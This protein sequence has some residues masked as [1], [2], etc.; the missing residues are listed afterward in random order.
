MLCPG[1]FILVVVKSPI[2]ACNENTAQ[3]I[4]FEKSIQFWL[5]ASFASITVVN[6]YVVNFRFFWVKIL[7]TGPGNLKSSG[8]FDSASRFS[9][10]TPENVHLTPSN[11]E[12]LIWPQ[13]RLTSRVSFKT[14]QF[15]LNLGLFWLCACVWESVNFIL[16][17]WQSLDDN[18][19]LA[20]LTLKFYHLKSE[21]Q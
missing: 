1:R 14:R 12:T 19:R 2:N 18:Q 15:S 7:M 20:R 11:I 17:A 5:L 8:Y 6:F 9:W 10:L 13:S 21:S 16:L 4:K 3:T